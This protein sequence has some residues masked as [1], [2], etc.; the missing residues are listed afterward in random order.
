MCFL[1]WL[2]CLPQQLAHTS[3]A[4]FKLPTLHLTLGPQQRTCREYTEKHSLP[5]C[6]A[7]ICS[8]HMPLERGFLLSK[9]SPLG[10]LG[11][12]GLQEGLQSNTPR[13]L[14]VALCWLLSPSVYTDSRF[15]H[16]HSQASERSDSK[17]TVSTSSPHS[18]INT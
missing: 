11:P 13:H 9:A 2:I 16:A 15:S 7:P 10:R 3:P 12:P 14:Q 17:L 18:L 8:H 4:F 1:S 5:S 6:P